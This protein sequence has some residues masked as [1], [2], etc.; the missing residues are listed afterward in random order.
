[1]NIRL[2]AGNAELRSLGFFYL[3]YVV[4]IS[5]LNLLLILA[6]LALT[7]IIIAERFRKDHSVFIRDQFGY[8]HFEI[9]S[10]FLDERTEWSDGES[11]LP[12]RVKRVKEI[13]VQIVED[14][15]TVEKPYPLLWNHTST[16][17]ISLDKESEH[18]C[19]LVAFEG[20]PSNVGFN[21][22]PS[23][24]S[25]LILFDETVIIH[26][27]NNYVDDDPNILAMMQTNY[28]IAP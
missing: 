7:M 18:W 25:A 1:M 15:S 27:A 12:L 23:T 21:G 6:L 28:V 19:F 4:R 5:I 11:E 26:R 14:I 22:P 9:S 20:Y 17:L 10:G 13:C 16:S 3:E 8:A 24:F 2:P